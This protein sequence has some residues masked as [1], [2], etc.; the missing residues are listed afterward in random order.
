[1]ELT[2]RTTAVVLDSTSDFVDARE[3]HENMRI[4]P[5]YVLFDGEPLRDQVDIGPGQFYERLA[6]A[7][8]LPT[9]SQPTPADFLACYQELVEAGYTRIWSLHLTS[10]LSGTHE[11][12][13]TAAKELGGDIVKVVDTQTASLAC[14]LLAEAIDRR[15]ERGT[16]D[17][18]VE[19][20]VDRFLRE[21]GVVFTV[22]TLEYLQKGGRIGKGQALAGSLLNVKPI[23]SV[24]DG[25]IVPVA[26][27]R[28][29]QKAL[30]EFERLFMAETEDREGLR[31]AIAHA[32]APEW[33]GELTE[34]A[35]RV[36]PKATIDLIEPLGA[37]VG[38]H[39]GPG[40]VGFFWFQD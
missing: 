22:G 1:M 30:K 10:K 26:R 25:V 8:S 15:L 33:I 9:T 32:N 24:E 6:A 31:L 21:N 39:T 19:Q 23:L 14:G 34:L 11:S 4:V 2:R 5:L 38:T 27:A 16:T 17:E 37:V 36:R 12:A 18:E 29:K 40:S 20:L 13:V 28:G 3:R 35:T 7:S